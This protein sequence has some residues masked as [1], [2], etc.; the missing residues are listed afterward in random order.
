MSVSWVSEKATGTLPGSTAGKASLPLLVCK[1]LHRPQQGVPLLVQGGALG[2]KGR[3]GEADV[4]R[5]MVRKGA[6]RSGRHLSVTVT[7]IIIICCCFW[8]HPMQAS[9]SSTWCSHDSQISCNF[10]PRM[11]HWLICSGGLWLVLQVWCSFS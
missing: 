5:G 10:C 2:G 1:T 3:G 8:Q 11:P 6:G 4:T 9:M 7:V